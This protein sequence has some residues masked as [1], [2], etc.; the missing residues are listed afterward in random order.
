MAPFTN[1]SMIAMAML[2]GAVCGGCTARTLLATFATPEGDRFARAIIDTLRE[3]PAQAMLPLL[4]PETALSTSIV[5]SL[6]SVKARIPTGSIDS[7]QIIGARVTR[8]VNGS[9]T[10]E[11]DY[12]L[13]AG[14]AWAVISVFT[15][16]SPSTAPRVSGLHAQLMPESLQSLNALSLRRASLAALAA[17]A[18]AL[19]AIGWSLYAAVQVV[20]SPLERR[21]LWV[22]V[23]LLGFGKLS[24]AWHTGEVTDHWLAIQL[25]GAGFVRDGFYGPWWI[26]VSLPG[27]AFIALDRRRRALAAQARAAALA[28]APPIAAVQPPQPTIGDIP[29]A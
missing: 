26:S 13:L 28:A 11:I 6:I 15:D 12:Q 9:T 22:I 29:G 14:G 10:R 17:V 1:R 25:L 19:V 21:W 2:V 4:T 23:A 18:I 7:L 5:D 3:R 8:R 16:E 20:R 27:G 24:V